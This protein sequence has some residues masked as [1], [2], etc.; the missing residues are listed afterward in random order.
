MLQFE[1]DY[2]EGAHPKL[3]E[4]LIRVNTEKTTGYGQDDHCFR[5]EKKRSS[6]RSKT[7]SAVDSPSAK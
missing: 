4:A 2:M 6:N 7:V 1:S 3:L 5:A